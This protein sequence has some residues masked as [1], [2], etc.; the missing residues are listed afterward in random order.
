MKSPDT[1]TAMVFHG[2]GHP[3]VY[4]TLPMP[5]PQAGQVLVKVIACGVCRTDLHIVDGE[6]SGPKLSLIPGHEIGNCSRNR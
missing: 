4:T 5:V 6:L 2:K 1:M 3:L